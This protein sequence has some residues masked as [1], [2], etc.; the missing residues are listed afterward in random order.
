[1]ADGQHSILAPSAAARWLACPPSAL[2]AE[3]VAEEQASD[4]AQEGTLAHRLAELNLSDFLKGRAYL[5]A[6]PDG[7]YLPAEHNPEAVAAMRELQRSPFYY[8]DMLSEVS[9]YCTHV[10][11]LFDAVGEDARM[12]VEWEVPLFYKPEDKGTL[13]SA[14]YGS[15]SRALYITDLKFGKGVRVEAEGNKQLLIYAISALDVLRSEPDAPRIDRVVMTI[16]QPR[17]N[18]VKTWTVKTPELKKLRAEIEAGA[19]LAL[20]GGGALRTGDHCR[21]CPAKP[22]CRAMHDN[23][24]AV[25][26]AEFEDPSLLTETEVGKLLG[27]LDVLIDWA[28]SVKQ[29]AL[30]RALDGT[31]YAGFK[32]VAGP[33][34]R[35]IS[36]ERAV[37]KALTAAGYDDVLITRQ[38]LIAISALEKML[39]ADTFQAC[40]A[41]YLTKTEPSPQLV[42]DTDPRPDWGPADA[43]AAFAEYDK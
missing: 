20:S 4:Y 40:C 33:S 39:P 18:S 43:A 8:A 24:A 27:T 1:M 14:V 16:V 6:H 34:R 38:S 32:L 12:R 13:D 28:S 17:L 7:T 21:F 10:K 25:A 30:R 9:R 22:L 19:R 11:G 36:D 2:L 3:K 31:R 5:A 15:K 37:V 35:K 42:P 29:Y 26:A 23:A 41:P